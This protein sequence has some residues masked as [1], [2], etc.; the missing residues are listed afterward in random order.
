M[1]LAEKLDQVISCQCGGADTP[2][3][4]SLLKPN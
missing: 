4:L 1:S 3:L 2:I